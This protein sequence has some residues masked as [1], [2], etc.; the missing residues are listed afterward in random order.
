MID[1]WPVLDALSA[2]NHLSSNAKYGREVSLAGIAPGPADACLHER[3]ADGD[4]AGSHFVRH[5]RTAEHRLG[6]GEVAREL[7]PLRLL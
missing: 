3:P 2:R 5:V 1:N 4:Q 6:D 7:A